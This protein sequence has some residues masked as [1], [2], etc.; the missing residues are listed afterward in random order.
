LI[1]LIELHG[2]TMKRYFRLDWYERSTAFVPYFNSKFDFGI[3]FYR[4]EQ[5]L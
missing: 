3:T 5:S 2:P 4:N 1:T